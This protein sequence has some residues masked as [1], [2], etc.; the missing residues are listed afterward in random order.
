MHKQREERETE[1]NGQLMSGLSLLF[2]PSLLHLKANLSMEMMKQPANGLFLVVDIGGLKAIEN[3]KQ[4]Y[5]G[6]LKAIENDNFLFLT[7]AGLYR[8]PS[9]L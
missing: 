9:K 1:L 6:G 8:W 3:E 7:K 4:V 5:T 2:F